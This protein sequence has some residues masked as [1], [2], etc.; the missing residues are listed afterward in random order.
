[1]TTEPAPLIGRPRHPAF[2]VLT[3]SLRSVLAFGIGIALLLYPDRG[4]EAVEG[5]MGVYFLVSGLFSLAWARRGPVLR[6]LA[7]VSGC[8]GVVTGASV[9]IYAVAGGQIPPRD[10][11]LMGLGLVI[12]LTGVLH[13]VGGFMVGERIDRWPAGHLL[14]GALEIALGAVLLFAPVRRE[15]IDAAATSGHSRPGPCLRSMPSGHIGVG[16]DPWRRH[17]AWIA[18]RSLNGVGRQVHEGVR[19]PGKSL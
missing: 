15:L 3:T 13:L 12:G 5:F 17:P 18:G 4:E 9:M 7:F 8:V 11:V 19:S 1:M 2:V 14:L 10:Q 16:P 6:R